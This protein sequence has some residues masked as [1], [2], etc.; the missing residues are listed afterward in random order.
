MR[1]KLNIH[2]KVTVLNTNIITIIPKVKAEI[3]SAFTFYK[4]S[5]VFK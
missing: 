1:K 4:G 3:F 5:E 2:S